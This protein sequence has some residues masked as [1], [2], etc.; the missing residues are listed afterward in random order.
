[1]KIVLAI[2]GYPLMFLMMMLILMALFGVVLP[3]IWVS[4][5]ITKRA[6][7]QGLMDAFNVA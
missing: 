4:D 1:M 2:V 7:L 5:K 3:C 6:D